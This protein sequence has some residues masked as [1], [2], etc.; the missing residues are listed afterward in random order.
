MTTGLKC[1]RI[2]LVANVSAMIR[3]TPGIVASLWLSALAS[4]CDLTDP[5]RRHDAE[6]GCMA[7]ERVDQLGSL[8]DQRLAHSQDR[9]LGLLGG[10]LHRHEPHP[11]TPGGL[12]NCLGIVA[13]IL[14]AFHEGLDILRRDQG[15]DSHCVLGGRLEW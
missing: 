3:P 10:G 8:A 5:L 4:R 7:A 6:F 9:S 2:D 13:V 14:G 11:R 1:R 15:S 12:A